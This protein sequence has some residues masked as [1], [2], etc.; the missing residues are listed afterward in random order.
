MSTS[1]SFLKGAL[2]AWFWSGHRRWLPVLALLAIY[3]SGCQSN[4]PD[5]SMIQ[6]QVYGEFHPDELARMELTI[7]DIVALEQRKDYGY[8]YDR[9]AG[10]GFRQRVRRDVFLQMGQCAEMHLGGVLSVDH[11]KTTYQRRPSRQA[12]EPSASAKARLPIADRVTQVIYRTEG[13]LWERLGLVPDG[14]EFKLDSFEWGSPRRT[15]L[16]CMEALQAKQARP[17]AANKLDANKLGSSEKAEKTEKT[18]KK[19]TSTEPE[20]PSETKQ[21]SLNNSNEPARNT[22]PSASPAKVTEPKRV[23]PSHPPAARSAAS[24]G[25]A[26]PSQSPS[27]ATPHSPAQESSPN[28][29]PPP[30][31]PHT[32]PILVDP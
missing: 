13:R 16:D 15:F 9:Y 24:T 1:H 31:L 22:L 10:P 5:Y 14:L 29:S 28:N 18:G 19:N 25:S 11:Q 2:T 23:K 4:Q 8:L 20:T 3:S 30:S 12:E 26:P 32:E 6:G 27:H 21:P 7:E 17:A